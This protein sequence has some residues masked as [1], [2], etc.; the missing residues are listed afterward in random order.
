[1]PLLYA[2]VLEKV[3]TLRILSLSKGSPPSTL[4][5]SKG[6]PP[7][8]LSLSKGSPPKSFTSPIRLISI[9]SILLW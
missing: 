4:S 1:M 6:S 3:A 9:R 8:I 7:T 2:V 5:L